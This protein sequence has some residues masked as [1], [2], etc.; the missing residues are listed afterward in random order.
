MIIFD[1]GI[2]K[3]CAKSEPKI[4]LTT[5]NI[6]H[7]LKAV[8][9]MFPLITSSVMID[10]NG[11]ININISIVAV[12]FITEDKVLQ[13]VLREGYKYPA[14]K[15]AKT[16]TNEIDEVIRFSKIIFLGVLEKCFK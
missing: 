11:S 13:V 15:D 3:S 9:E 4:K 2:N 14:Y 6:I 16:P 5:I 8:S 7:L 12:L 1:A 10:R